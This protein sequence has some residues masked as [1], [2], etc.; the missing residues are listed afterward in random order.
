MSQL[1]IVLLNCLH[2]ISILQHQEEFLTFIMLIQQKWRENLS[3][4]RT[5]YISKRKVSVS[6]IWKSHSSQLFSEEVTERVCCHSSCKLLTETGAQSGQ[7]M[8]E[9]KHKEANKRKIISTFLRIF[10]RFRNYQ[11]NLLDNLRYHLQHLW[12]SLTLCTI[13]LIQKTKGNL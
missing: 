2:K 6:C 5:L 13:L 3:P 1:V 9:K 8:R 4:L 7:R 10:K 12:H 11:N